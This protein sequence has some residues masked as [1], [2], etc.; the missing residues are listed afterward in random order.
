MKK[1]A[2]IL[3]IVALVALSLSPL[4]FINPNEVNAAEIK[5][6]QSVHQESTVVEM[7]QGNGFLEIDESNKNVKITDEYKKAVLENIEP[8]YEAVFT[9]NSVSIVPKIQTFSAFTGVDKIVFT[10]KG[11]DV[12]LSNEKA[13]KTAAGIGLLA[14]ASTL[15]P[16]A[17]I[18][19]VLAVTLGL[20]SG[21]ISLNNS[22]GR[23]VII[24]YIGS[25]YTNSMPDWITSQ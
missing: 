1:Q 22:E 7:L 25:I 17:T 19:K 13:T 4:N 6:E 5:T 16:E 12:Y 20:G 23:G 24:A 10:W 11:Y 15:I 8:G 2:K 18:S 21:L 9:D 3:G 14:T